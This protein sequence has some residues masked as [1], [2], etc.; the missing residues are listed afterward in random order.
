MVI[1]TLRIF[2]KTITMLMLYTNITTVCTYEAKLKRLYH[3]NVNSNLLR[4]ATTNR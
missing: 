4:S 1:T 2:Y 3:K